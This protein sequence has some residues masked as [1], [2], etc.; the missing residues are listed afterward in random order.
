MDMLDKITKVT[1]YT[2]IELLDFEDY[3]TEKYQEHIGEMEEPTSDI[4][5]NEKAIIQAID[6]LTIY[7]D[8]DS[9]NVVHDAL[10]D[11]LKIFESGEWM[12]MIF[13]A[14]V[15]TLMNKVQ[16]SYLD[17]Y[18][19]YLLKRY[20]KEKHFIKQQMIERLKDYYRFIVCFDLEPFVKDMRDEVITGIHTQTS[21]YQYEELCYP[22]Y[23]DIRNNIK[24]CDAK[25]IRQQV[26]N[27]IK[28][29]NKGATMEINMKML[30]L[31]KADE[32][33]KTIVFERLQA[34][35]EEE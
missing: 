25:R 21:T 33:F 12:S 15:D 16:S 2:G 20:H 27:V 18:E 34:F 4:E 19:I 26:S 32:R 5:L 7:S 8:V 22:M 14:G 6:Q 10:C 29:N 9:L 17:Y 24:H 23:I 35:E 13:D 11:R 1:N 30:D 28:K 31:M 3:V